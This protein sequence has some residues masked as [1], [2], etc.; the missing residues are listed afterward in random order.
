MD[1]L[2]LTLG[3]TWTLVGLLIAASA[4]PLVRGRVPP[5]R[6]YGV[7]FRECY[8]SDEAWFA[9][10]HFGGKRLLL[11]SIP[12]VLLG[13]VTLFLPLRLHPLLTLVCATLLFA[14][15]LIPT[16]E[17]ARFAKTFRRKT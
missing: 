15:V 8:Q 7:K 4:I 6:F 3:L 5:N 13:I 2:A 17:I 16:I 14:F 11:W 9:I 10:N 12:I 1:S